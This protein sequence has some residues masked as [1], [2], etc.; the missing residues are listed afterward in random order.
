[1]DDGFPACGVCIQ[2]SLKWDLPG[3]VEHPEHLHE[4]SAFGILELRMENRSQRR[5][6]NGIERQ[7][8]HVVGT[9]LKQFGLC[10]RF[11]G[12]VGFAR[13]RST[14]AGDYGCCKKSDQPYQR[15]VGCPHSY[16]HSYPINFQTI[17]SCVSRINVGRMVTRMLAR[18]ITAEVIKTTLIL[19]RFPSSMISSFSR[20][21]IAEARS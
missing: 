3:I 9:D 14:T 5:F 15:T 11:N 4:G 1:M 13:R 19:A 2:P 7:L 12:D 10:W 8:N 16:L 6:W 17:P 18:R 20:C 21:R